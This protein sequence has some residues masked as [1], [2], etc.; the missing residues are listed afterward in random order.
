MRTGL[1]GEADAPAVEHKAHRHVDVVENETGGKRGPELPAHRVDGARDADAGIDASLPA[2]EPPL[3]APVSL[4]EIA[5]SVRPGEVEHAGD[6]TELG[7][8]ELV[9]KGRNG[10]RLEALRCIGKDEKLVVRMPDGSI[11]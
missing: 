6:C 2:P 7:V 11:E 10:V 1:V 8:A 4:G 9:H 3:V 5:H